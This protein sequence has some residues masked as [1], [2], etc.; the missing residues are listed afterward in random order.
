VGNP[1]LPNAGR[2]ADAAAAFES[3]IEA[4]RALDRQQPNDARVQRFIGVSLERVGTLHEAAGRWKE[5]AAAY[6]ASYD[7][8][9]SLADREPSHRNIQRDLAIAHEKLGKVAE[10]SG[11]TAA[12]IRSLRRALEQF[13]RLA[14]LD[15]ADANAVR[16][17]AISRELLGR[18]MLSARRGASRMASKSMGCLLPDRW[19]WDRW[20]DGAD[21]S[22]CGWR[23]RPAPPCGRRACGRSRS[24]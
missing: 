18:A 10:A 16:S 7:I 1:N 8:R 12:G 5:A 17:V 9:Q 24:S 2:A 19:T 21:A 23:L 11:D 22:G 20:L 13:E 6:R 14:A 3:G 15:T 4:F